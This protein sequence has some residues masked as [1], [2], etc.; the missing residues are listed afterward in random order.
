MRSVIGLRMGAVLGMFFL[1]LATKPAM[2]QDPVKIAPEQYKVVLENDRV[3]VLEAHLRPGEKT[4]MH[5]HPANV[6][7][8]LTDSKTKFTPA[9]GKGTVRTMKA[10]SAIWAPPETHATVNTGTTEAHVVIFEFKTLGKH[11]KAASGPDPVKAD[12]SHF[13]V[14]LNNASV[15]VLEFRAKPG[16]KVPM[17][18]HPSYITYNI[19]GGKTIFTFPDGKTAERDAVAGSV[20][21]N[22]SEAHAAQVGGTEGH[23]ILV[24]LKA[25]REK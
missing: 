15:R 23:S 11:G 14:L 20:T 3:R 13:K 21:W 22:E 18:S 19:G 10:G 7:Y 2:A 8:S 1:A 24:E 6:V 12:P 25:H 9:G 17:H 4:A 16:D 5:S